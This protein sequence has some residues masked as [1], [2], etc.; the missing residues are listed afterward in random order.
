MLFTLGVLHAQLESSLQ[1]SAFRQGGELLKD[2]G[3]EEVNVVLLQ[4]AVVTSTPPGT[5]MLDRDVE[6]EKSNMQ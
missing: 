6:G 1:H 4:P 2:S 3:D 5:V